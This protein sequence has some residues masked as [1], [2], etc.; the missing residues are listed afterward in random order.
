MVAAWL[1][2]ELIIIAFLVSENRRLLGQAVTWSPLLYLGGL[3]GLYLALQTGL[4]WFTDSGRMA[5]ALLAAVA[6]LTVG[7]I[8]LFTVGRELLPVMQRLSRQF[9]SQKSMAP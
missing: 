2:C 8:G 7:F 3:A 9:L 6:G 5:Q 1:C 4:G